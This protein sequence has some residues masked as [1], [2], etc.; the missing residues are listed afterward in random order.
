MEEKGEGKG[1]QKEVG[2]RV[3]ELISSRQ[4]GPGEDSLFQRTGKKISQI[5]ST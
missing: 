4:K 2:G 3:R 5:Y 1:E